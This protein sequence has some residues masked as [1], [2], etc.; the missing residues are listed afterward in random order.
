MAYYPNGTSGV[1]FDKGC[2]DCLHEELDYGCP[3]AFIQM[4]YNYS[5]HD[6]EKVKEILDY[7]VDQEKGCILRDKIMALKKGPKPDYDTMEIFKRNSTFSQPKVGRANG[8]PSRATRPDFI[9]HG[10]TVFR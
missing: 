6:H 3:I 8:N 4:N 5:Q 2:V 9:T 7:L 10:N 1:I